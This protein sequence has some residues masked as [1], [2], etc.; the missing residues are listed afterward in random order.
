MTELAVQTP[1]QQC[2]SLLDAFER[3]RMSAAAFE[4]CSD[5]L[6]MIDP[7]KWPLIF[8]ACVVASAAGHSGYADPVEVPL[9]AERTLHELDIFNSGQPRPFS[10]RGDFLAGI[11]YDFFYNT[12]SQ[13]YGHAPKMFSE[14]R[15]A[16]IQNQ[17][18]MARYA[19]EHPEKMLLCHYNFKQ[20]KIMRHEEFAGFFPGHWLYFPG[21]TLVHPLS[22]SGTVL[23]VENSANFLEREP[24]GSSISNSVVALI[25]LDASGAR[26]WDRAE[27]AV[28]IS[29]SGTSLTVERGLFR[30]SAREYPAGTYVAVLPDLYEGEADTSFR[31]NWSLDCPRD[32]QG[33]NCGD[34][35]VRMMADYLRPGAPLEKVHGI[36]A[37]V[38]FWSIGDPVPPADQTKR[39]FDT[40]GDGLADNGYDAQ[41][42]NRFALGVYD[43]VRKLRIVLGPGRIF[44]GDGNGKSWPRLPHLMNGMESEGLSRWNDPFS[45]NWSSN[46]NLFR[47]WTANPGFDQTLN[48]IVDKLPT[49]EDEELAEHKLHLKRLAAATAAVLDIGIT[50]DGSSFPRSAGLSYRLYDHLKQGVVNRLGWL[51]EP[52]EWMRPA[53]NAPNLFSGTASDWT[54][55]DA[56]IMPD[57]EENA[58]RVQT[59]GNPSGPSSQTM[60]I[61]YSGLQIPEG[62]LFFRFEMKAAPLAAFSPDVYRYVTVTVDGRQV[63]TNTADELTAVASS[64][65]YSECAFYYREAGPATV[66]INLTFEGPQEVWI[67]NFSVHNAADVFARGFENGVVLANP[68]NQPHTFNLKE[69]F[70]DR[71]IWRLTGNEWEDLATHSGEPVG[72]TVTVPALD[73][74]FLRAERDSDG[75]GLP[76]AWEIQYF[77]GPT[78]ADASARAACGKHTV[79]EAYL[80]GSDPLDAESCLQI[81]L[82][83]LGGQAAVLSWPGAPDRYYS[84]WRAEDLRTGWM[85]YTHQIGRSSRPMSLELNPGGLSSDL[86]DC[87]FFRVSVRPL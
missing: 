65:G 12:I 20:I 2:E 15:V 82:E 71:I 57:P 78:A 23:T 19:L 4:H 22:A 63:N 1:D 7:M 45:K 67:K 24:Y 44:C 75:D 6:W 66:G 5:V 84:V 58:W 54:S 47:Y 32:E 10:F 40:D 25:P 17:P 18:F 29:K 87:G 81:G 61:R 39:R 8:L 48:F 46:P 64:H 16:S 52:D 30:T 56:S 79:Y 26:Q 69:L 55:S 27:F 60:T 83:G 9:Y 43:M 14:E 86:A 74:L 42:E 53:T 28:M 76:D 37:D 33:M 85:L 35:F 34:V 13:S 70:P 3:I 72:D 50:A 59:L 36:L 73:G 77:G 11:S 41:G 31:F 51:G 62:D 21:S 38:L 49:L 80:A 68:R